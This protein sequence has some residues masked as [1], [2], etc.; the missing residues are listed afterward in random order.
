MHKITGIATLLMGLALPVANQP[1]ETSITLRV[2]SMTE[3]PA[4]F[5]VWTRGSARRDGVRVADSVTKTTPA[6]I[7][8]DSATQEIRVVT[9][10]N[11]PVRVRVLDGSRE[12]QRPANAWGRDLRLVRDDSLFQVVFDARLLRPR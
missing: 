3:R 2:D 4:M 11:A 12:V 8:L 1:R 10:A 9:K 5:T 7:S 6:S